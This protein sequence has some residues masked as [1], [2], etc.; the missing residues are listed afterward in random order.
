MEASLIVKYWVFDTHSKLRY[1]K[2]ESI[3]VTGESQQAILEKIKKTPDVVSYSYIPSNLLPYK[4]CNLNGAYYQNEA[5]ILCRHLAW[6]WLL[7]FNHNMEKV[8]A[9]MQN[10]KDCA[11]VIFYL[12][13]HNLPGL[14]GQ[15]IKKI[16]D[17]QSADRAELLNVRSAGAVPVLFEALQEG[18]HEVVKVYCDGIL[19]SNLD[20]A[21]KVKLLAAKN[22]DGTSG[23]FMALQEGHCETVKVYCEAILKYNFD[24]AT[25]IKLLAALDNDG[26]SGLHMALQEGKHEVVKAYCDAILSSNLNVDAKK[27]LL[28]PAKVSY[29]NQATKE[30]HSKAIAAITALSIEN[31]KHDE[32]PAKKRRTVGFFNMPAATTLIADKGVEVANVKLELCI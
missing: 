11:D 24:T 13:K 8:L 27:Q 25:T 28:M 19:S 29:G 2:S 21:E 1:L 31:T 22:A 4:D 23:L 16:L 26:F 15:F 6:A 3:D 12:M 32:Q 17:D 14:L 18:Y 9:Q 7:Y 30:V 10:L 20:D 5:P